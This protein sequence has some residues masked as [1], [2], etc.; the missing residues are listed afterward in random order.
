[1]NVHSIRDEKKSFMCVRPYPKGVFCA[2]NLARIVARAKKDQERT[3]I[4]AAICWVW[5][6]YHASRGPSRRVEGPLGIMD[7]QRRRK[8][9]MRVKW[10]A[11]RPEPCVLP[12]THGSNTCPRFL[13]RFLCWKK[14]SLRASSLLGSCARFVR[15]RSAIEVSLERIR[16]P[17]APE[18]N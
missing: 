8:H 14:K 18:I 10:R 3:S 13:H 1:M 15:V 17:L 9:G 16:L 6:M 7:N 12:R 4:M 5:Q 2:L 11:G